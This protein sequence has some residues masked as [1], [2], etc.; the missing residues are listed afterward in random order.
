MLDKFMKLN[1]LYFICSLI[2][3]WIYLTCYNITHRSG[4]EWVCSIGPKIP[5]WITKIFVCQMEHYFLPGQTDL[6]LFPLGLISH[7]DL[8]NKMLKDNNEVAVL[9]AVSSMQRN[10]TC[11]H[12]TLQTS[13]IFTRPTQELFSCHRTLANFSRGRSCKPGKY[14]QEIWND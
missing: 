8:L 4:G 2:Y 11:I 5:V 13:G 7:Q 14:P 3:S 12:I 6:V 9:R 10:L 1:S